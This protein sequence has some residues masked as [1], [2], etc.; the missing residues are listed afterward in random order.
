MR[1]RDFTLPK[2]LVSLALL[3][4]TAAA[5]AAGGKTALTWYGHAA[6]KLQT[7][8][9]KVILIDPWITNPTNPN[10]AKDLAALD[11]VDLILV[12]HGHTDHIGDAVAIA[13]RTKAPL[14]ATWDLGNMIVRHAGYPSAQFSPATGGNF[15]GELTLLDGEVTVAFVPAVHSSSVTSDN[16]TP[17]EQ[18]HYGGAPGGFV[19]S[20]KGGPTIYH[21]GDTDLF[22]DMAL[23]PK[24]HKVDVMLA[25][26][27][28]HF[29]MGPDRA[30][31]AVKL[32]NP[33]TVVP[34]HFGTYPMLAGTPDALGKALKAT[35]ARAQ[36]HAMKIGD[37]L[38]L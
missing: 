33:A 5:H 32:V 25:C 35:H 22:G 15:G 11:K 18:P 27:G 20:V 36:L 3:L 6:F 14:V 24:L 21:T 34:M 2:L 17:Q 4:S 12:T 1:R 37:T 29:T 7:P 31:E 30:A 13:K 23:I 28:G 16:N 8:A 9:G 38:P 10:G 26:I 19:V